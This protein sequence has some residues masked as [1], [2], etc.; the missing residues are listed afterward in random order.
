M[1]IHYDSLLSVSD[2]IRRG[3]LTSAGVTAE[4]LDRIAL[5][6]GRLHSTLMVLADEAMAEAQKADAEIARG[7]WRG[8]LH[9]IPIGVK[10]LLWTKGLPTTGGMDLLRDFRPEEDATVVARLRDAG[11]VI[12]AKLN[13]TEGATFNHHPVFSRP[14]NPWGRAYW[15]GVSSSGSGVAPAAGFC[16][17]AIGS[18]TGGSIRMPSA[19]NNLT[20]IKPTWGRVSRH[21]LIHLAESLDHLGPMA[22]SA[23]DA[24]AILQAIAGWDPKDATSLLDPVPDYLA[25]M[26][27][28][29]A[30]LTLGIDWQF[31]AGGM[32]GEIVASLENARTVLEGLGMKVRDVAFPLDV[33]EM[34]ESQALFGAEI[35][36]AHEAWFPEQA[37]RYGTW[38]RRTL[39]EMGQLRGVDVARGH[40]LRER[41]R[42]RL[43]ALF[44][45]VDMLLVPAL[46]KPLPTW[47]EMEPM[48]QGEAPMDID[49]LRFT[50]PF[51]LSGSPTIT[52]PAGVDAA[53][54]PLGIQLAGTWLAE[55]ALIRAGVA[56]QKATAFHERHPD[57]ESL[58]AV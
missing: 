46:G 30:G 2:R 52:L 34:A 42:G 12:I 8:P 50:S 1:P 38:L 54:M 24:A 5:L 47:E 36:L 14:V 3:E 31:A 4:L 56:F 17:G 58:A 16:F 27:G 23:G 11:A 28:G 37:D 6:D 9:G 13:M 57:L 22:R 20:G 7:Q 32:A 33:R 10:D 41:Y 26:D 48:A 25:Q 21:G 53:G 39:G 18:D 29:V 15:T 43:R 51:N 44:A 49:L 55:P 45:E 19:A 35:A 40:M